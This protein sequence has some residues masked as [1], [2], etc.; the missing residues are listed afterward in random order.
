MSAAIYSHPLTSFVSHT[1]F[2]ACVELYKPWV[3]ATGA[4]ILELLR[5]KLLGGPEPVSE[6]SLDLIG[7]ISLCCVS[8]L[9][10][11]Q[12]KS[13]PEAASLSYGDFYQ[14][15][16][17]KNQNF[18]HSWVDNLFLHQ[19]TLDS[20]LIALEL[21][22]LQNSGI[23]ILNQDNIEIYSSYLLAKFLKT[24]G[25]SSKDTFWAF[26]ERHTH[27]IETKEN[28]FFDLENNID[29]HIQSEFKKL[30][31]KVFQQFFD[32]TIEAPALELGVRFYLIHEHHSQS[33]YEL[34]EKVNFL[35]SV[36]DRQAAVHFVAQMQ[37]ASSISWGSNQHL[38]YGVLL[39]EKFVNHIIQ[40]SHAPNEIL[41]YLL[42]CNQGINISED[43]MAKIQ[44]IKDTRASRL[45]LLEAIPL[46]V[47]SADNYQAVYQ[48]D[49]HLLNLGID[50]HTETHSSPISSTSKTGQA[51]RTDKVFKL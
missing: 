31:A 3:A 8:E 9:I 48:Q 30:P 10:Y 41:D 21:S 40:D 24:C 12:E 39:N 25:I 17:F 4:Q 49:G 51:Q 28:F 1:Q 26:C 15:I 35:F 36:E 42:Y 44:F 14:Q 27:Y 18:F 5:S 20:A 47:A 29:T 23:K 46:V 13:P 43:F 50:T 37:D 7:F 6:A 16:D 11:F 32:A 34:L 19:F 22:H 45:A 2:L 33:F 38:A